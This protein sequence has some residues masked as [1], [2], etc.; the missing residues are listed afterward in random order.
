MGV[1]ETGAGE[2]SIE[3]ELF[4]AGIVSICGVADLGYASVL[5]EYRS[6]DR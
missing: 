1:V 5:D 3:R 6:H 2:S 4:C